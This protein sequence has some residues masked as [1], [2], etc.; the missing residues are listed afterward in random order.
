[1][2]NGWYGAHSLKGIYNLYDFAEDP[3][4]HK[5][6]KNFLHL[7][8]AAWAQEQING[9]RGGGKSRIYPQWYQSGNSQIREFMWFYLGIGNQPDLWAERATV[10]T[11]DYRLPL[12]VMDLAL[13]IEGRGEYEVRNRALGLNKPGYEYRYGDHRL[14]SDFGGRLRYAAVTP[15]FIMGMPML[16]ARHLDDWTLIAVLRER[17]GVIFRGGVS[18]QIMPINEGAAF[19]AQWGVQRKGTMIIQALPKPYAKKNGDMRVWLGGNGLQNGVERDG[20]LFVETKGAYAAV[21]PVRGSYKLQNGV[22]KLPDSW[23]D[24]DDNTSPVILEVAR[25]TRFDDYKAF[26]DAV[27]ELSQTWDGKTLHYKGLYGDEFAFD[28]GYENLPKINGEPIDLAPDRVY[29]SP[30]VKSEWNSGVVAISK[31]DRELV[32]EF[33]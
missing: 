7:Y 16:E 31:G 12:V 22:N 11:S 1:M 30:F 20:W 28:T 23:M 19:N 24:I 13:D 33:D 6:A 25:K 29:D 4:L 26:Q 10:A 21:R 15:D 32:L 14:R 5:L 9:V 27:L 18:D 17:M 2:D 8:Y 3:Q